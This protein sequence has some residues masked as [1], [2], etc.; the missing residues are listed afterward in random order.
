MRKPFVAIIAVEFTSD[1]QDYLEIVQTD[2]RQHYGLFVSLEATVQ[3]G[4]IISL[5]GSVQSGSGVWME[6]FQYTLCL[7]LYSVNLIDLHHQIAIVVHWAALVSANA[8]VL[9]ILERDDTL[10]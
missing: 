10:S 7:E 2:Y 4:E 1:Q 9:Q 3:P 6:E 5:G 8:D